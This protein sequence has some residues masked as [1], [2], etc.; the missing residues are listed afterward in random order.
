MAKNS[1][2]RSLELTEDE[3]A[4]RLSLGIRIS[5]R[6]Y[7]VLVHM[8]QGHST[9]LTGEQIG[10]TR[11]TVKVLRRQ[12]FRSLGVSKISE[13]Y[14]FAHLLGVTP[15]KSGPHATVTTIMRDLF[16]FADAHD[17]TLVPDCRV[18]IAEILP[19]LWAFVAALRKAV[20]NG[21]K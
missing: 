11:G 6:E 9:K 1:K 19:Q 3:E 13:V 10:I 17:P 18:P 20:P 4:R 15:G 14:S 21:R 2:R 7:Q 12:I 16:A 8:A 5:R